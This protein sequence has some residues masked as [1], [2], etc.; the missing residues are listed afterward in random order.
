[1]LAGLVAWSVFLFYLDATANAFGVDGVR[2][3]LEAGRQPLTGAALTAAENDI[4]TEGTGAFQLFSGLNQAGNVLTTA[5]TTAEGHPR[6]PNS[7]PRGCGPMRPA[8]L[9]R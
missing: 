2:R 9:K 1:L 7:W 4:T 8:P 5:V 3:I 6:E